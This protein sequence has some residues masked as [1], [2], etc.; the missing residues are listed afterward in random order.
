LAEDVLKQEQRR[1]HH[2]DHTML[3]AKWAPA[4]EKKKEK[5]GG[6]T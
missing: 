4:M 2:L 6:V 5:G 1:E 3:G